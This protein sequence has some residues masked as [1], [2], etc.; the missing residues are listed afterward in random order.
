MYPQKLGTFA[1][2]GAHDLSMKYAR[3][4]APTKAGGTKYKYPAFKACYDVSYGVDGL[5]FGDWYL[6]SSFEGCHLMADETL[7]I[8]APSISKMGTT[9]INNGATR[10]FAERCSAYHAR[11]FSG[12]AGYLDYTG[13]YNAFR[14]QAVTLLD[15]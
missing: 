15:I 13:V 14:V 3:A 6:P 2:P 1:L 9:A 8:L 10:W 11:I 4:A 5:D 12:G 7:A